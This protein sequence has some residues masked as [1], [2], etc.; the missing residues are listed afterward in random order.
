MLSERE[1]LE[2]FLCMG[3]YLD[4]KDGGLKKKRGVVFVIGVCVLKEGKKNV[5]TYTS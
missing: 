2:L 5:R 3:L 4:Y 1:E